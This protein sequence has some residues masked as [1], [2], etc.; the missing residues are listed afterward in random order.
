[1]LQAVNKLSARTPPN[2]RLNVLRLSCGLKGI[3]RLRCTLRVNP[4][5]PLALRLENLNGFQ[6]QGQDRL[7]EGHVSFGAA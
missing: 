4:G 1:M 7:D 6:Q 3:F 2:A 5:L